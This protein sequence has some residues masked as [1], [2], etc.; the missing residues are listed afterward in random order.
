[1][2]SSKFFF[3]NENKKKCCQIIE[4]RRKQRVPKTHK[5]KDSESWRNLEEQK[6]LNVQDFKCTERAPQTLLSTEKERR[7][8]EKNKENE[9][10]RTVFKQ[11]R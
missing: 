6:A 8:R 11:W 4:A 2:R 10:V 1:M 7:N 9:A 3:G 5:N